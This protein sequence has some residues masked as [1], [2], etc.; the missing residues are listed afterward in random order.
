MT[1][2]KIFICLILLTIINFS[3]S[4]YVRV[5]YYTNWAQYRNG[6]AKF[7]PKDIDPYLC[8]HIV[9]AFAKIVS[10]RLAPYEWNDREYANYY[11]QVTDLKKINPSL[12][13]L[14]A[15]G[16]W[17]HE[18]GT[19]SPFSQMVA[20]QWSREIFIDDSINYLRKY[21]FDG[22]DLDWEYP[23]QRG[24]SPPEDKQKFTI[25]CKEL[26]EAFEYEETLSGKSRLMLTAAV[27]AGATKIRSIYE[28]GKLGMYLDSLHLMSYDLAGSW[29]GKTGHHTAIKGNDGLTVT[30][31]LDVWINNGFS[32]NK[33]SGRVCNI[34]FG[35]VHET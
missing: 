3:C 1:T 11:K 29:L 32:R 13:V 25:L 20:A 2:L 30:A 24:N 34:A 9:Y 10:S 26:K 14:L 33:V 31:G 22:L 19:T 27:A 6:N 15:V 21:N 8:T 17:T 28:V 12:K 5:C 23:T 7:L 18:G 16:G 35:G 4:N